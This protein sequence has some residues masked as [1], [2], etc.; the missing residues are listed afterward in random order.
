MLTLTSEPPYSEDKFCTKSQSKFA[1]SDQSFE[2]QEEELIDFKGK[3]QMEPN[4]LLSENIGNEVLNISSETPYY[5]DNFD[6]KLQANFDKY[7]QILK[8]QE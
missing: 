7:D 5:E 4:K 1:T 2:N 8:Q 3:Q 6:T